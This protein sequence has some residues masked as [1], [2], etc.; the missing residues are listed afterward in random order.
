MGKEEPQ[1]TITDE[2]IFDEIIKEA[3]SKNQGSPFDVIGERDSNE[4]SRHSGFQNRMTGEDELYNK[5]MNSK[6]VKKELPILKVSFDFNK[7]PDA[8]SLSKEHNVLG[9][10]FYKYKPMIQKAN[11]FIKQRR[12]R[13]ALNYYEVIL[14]QNISPTFKSMIRQNIKD[15]TDYLERYLA[16]D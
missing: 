11:D 8:N 6:N 5:F 7:L 12:V 13:E 16:D 10:S 9:Y 1:D 2:E 4:T 15:L 3:E 14:N